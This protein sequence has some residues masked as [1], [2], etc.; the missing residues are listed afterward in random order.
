MR[1]I[2][3]RCIISRNQAKAAIA[4]YY[5]LEMKPFFEE[6]EYISPLTAGM[7]LANQPGLMIFD[8]QKPY[9]RYAYI[10]CNPVQQ[11]IISSY[12]AVS[13]FKILAEQH[14]RYALETIA[15]LPP[16]QTGWAGYLAYEAG[17]FVERMPAL[18]GHTLPLAVIHQYG[19]IL[20]IDTVAK[21][22]W[23]VASGWPETDSVSR[24]QMAMQ[25]IK[26]LKQLLIVTDSGSGSHGEKLCLK[27]VQ[28]PERFADNVAKT[29]D[30]IY[31]GD[32]YQ[33]NISQ[34]FAADYRHTL[35]DFWPRLRAD[36]PAPYGAYM[37]WQGG[38]I[39]SCSP[40][41]F[42][43]VQGNTITTSPIKGTA[44]PEEAAALQACPKN[45]AENRMIVDLLRHDI[46]KSAVPGSVKVKA[47]AAI[48]QY[49][50][51]CHLVSTITG[52]LSPG[53]TAI[54]AMASAF[55]GGSITGAPK[56]R[57]MEII[58]ELEQAPRGP[59][60]GSMFYLGHDGTMDS[61]ILIRTLYS[62][63]NTVTLDAGCGI[64]ADSTPAG[65]AEESLRK[66]AQIRN[67]LMKE[68]GK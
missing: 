57:A 25:Q 41:Q 19:A 15:E 61:S 37:N 23:L 55:P 3:R 29:I 56:V 2:T 50:N 46:A 52:Q 66:A 44:A 28:P 65:E 10:G 59:Y 51:L 22:S 38:E 16:W 43:K 45:Q 24:Q 1:L 11:F 68:G 8:Q 20:S 48:E 54:D 39:L 17:A 40:E 27:P 21:R 14:G 62:D 9:G 6:I 33:A 12:D 36:N 32:I 63:G 5:N 34:R 26:N 67:I 35:L 60:C 18:S 4:L 49:P 53:K 64:V 42:I 58:A 47:F 13:P 31:R 30:Y 7:Q